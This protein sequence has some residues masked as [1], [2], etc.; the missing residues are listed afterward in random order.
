MQVLENDRDRADIGVR[1]EQFAVAHD[2]DV[3]RTGR[4]G[5]IGRVVGE[6][7]RIEL[8]RHGDV[9]P[10]PVGIGAAIGEI[11]GELG[12]GDLSAAVI[13]RDPQR[14]EPKRMNDRRHAVVDGIANHLGVGA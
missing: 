2:E 4:N 13:G 10:A 11:G 14:L 5:A 1:G 7:D 3:G 6:R 9:R 12:A 8:E